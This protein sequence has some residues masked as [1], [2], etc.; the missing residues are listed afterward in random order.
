MN[1]GEP[2]RTIIVEPLELPLNAHQSL[3]LASPRVSQFQLPNDDPGSHLSNHRVSRLAMGRV[4][5]CI[6]EWAPVARRSG[7]GS[8]VQPWTTPSS[9][10]K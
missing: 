10:T 8:N 1:I 7:D 3:N 6:I 4:K 2:L 9:S 5:N